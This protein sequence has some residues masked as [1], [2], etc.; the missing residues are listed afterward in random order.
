MGVVALIVRLYLEAMRRTAALSF[1]VSRWPSP[2]YCHPGVPWLAFVMLLACFVLEATVFTYT[3]FPTV[4]G[5][6]SELSGEPA[7]RF[8][9]GVLF[10]FLLMLVM[11][12]FACLQTLLDAARTRELKFI[13]QIV[14]I[15]LLVMFFEV[16]FL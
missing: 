14:V 8:T 3:M 1:S 16:M 2:S 5:V 15:E 6:L 7:S 11:G 9:G 13:A 12:S 4:T 10:T